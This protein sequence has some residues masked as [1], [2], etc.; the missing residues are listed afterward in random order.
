MK[1]EFKDWPKSAALDNCIYR[2]VHLFHIKHKMI[3]VLADP[4]EKPKRKKPGTAMKRKVQSIPV[5][6]EGKEI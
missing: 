6:D 3:F 1:K 5:D 4:L 2:L